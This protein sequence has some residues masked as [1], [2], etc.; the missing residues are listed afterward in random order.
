MDFQRDLRVF[1]EIE[2]ALDTCPEDMIAFDDAQTEEEILAA[3]SRVEKNAEELTGQEWKARVVHCRNT[4]LHA[5]FTYY[6]TEHKMRAC[7]VAKQVLKELC[8][9]F[10]LWDLPTER[11]ERRLGQ[12]REAMQ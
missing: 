3:I 5:V 4:Y 1:L 10:R 8:G 6:A 9:L 12:I 2:T 7:K 11:L